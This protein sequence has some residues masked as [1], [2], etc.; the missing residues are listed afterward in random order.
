MTSRLAVNHA[1]ITY[2]D[3]A[4]HDDDGSPLS[5]K[6]LW[7][8]LHLRVISKH[9]CKSRK[10]GRELNESP[11]ADCLALSWTLSCMRPLQAFANCCA[12]CFLT[13]WR[14]HRSAIASSHA[15]CRQCRLSK[16][17]TIQSCGQGALINVRMTNWAKW[18][19]Q[20]QMS[21]SSEQ[22]LLVC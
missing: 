21:M 9:I 7:L 22:M 15:R 5:H 6:L 8:Q 12:K 19:G 2:S 1:F 18:E 3:N 20:T 14:A 13:L 10:G 16:A 17:T 4:R 11:V